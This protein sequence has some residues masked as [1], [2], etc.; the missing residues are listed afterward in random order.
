MNTTHSKMRVKKKR[1][2]LTLTF[3]E[4]LNLNFNFKHFKRFANSISA[5]FPYSKQI[6]KKLLNNKTQNMSKKIVSHL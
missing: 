2:N 5:L 3:A 4:L 1:R 6:I